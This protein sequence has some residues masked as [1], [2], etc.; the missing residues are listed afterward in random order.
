MDATAAELLLRHK[1]LSLFRKAGERIALLLSWKHSG[2]SV[3]NAVSVELEDP[4]AA[5]Q[6]DADEPVAR[7]IAQQENSRLPLVAPTEVL[8][9]AG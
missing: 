8:G 7:V 1:V 2:F 3:H 6:L 4:G 5:E 9:A